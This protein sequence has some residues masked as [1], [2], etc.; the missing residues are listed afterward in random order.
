MNVLSNQDNIPLWWAPPR[1]KV[2]RNLRLRL[3][4]DLPK[5]LV[6]EHDDNQAFERSFETPSVYQF[7]VSRGGQPLSWAPSRPLRKRNIKMT[8]KARR[9]DFNDHAQDK[10]QSV[11]D[12]TESP[13][14][15]NNET[16]E[17]YFPHGKELTD[18]ENMERVDEKSEVAK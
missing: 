5:R 6:F 13:I 4:N 10:Y 15:V 8:Y 14:V 17:K 16:L 12:T 9:L 2:R 11:Q 7:R 3:P 1:P 18:D